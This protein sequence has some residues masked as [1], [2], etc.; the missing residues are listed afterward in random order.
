MSTNPDSAS[1]Y[2]NEGRSRLAI[3]LASQ[4][5]ATT[6]TARPRD[7]LHSPSPSATIIGMQSASEAFGTWA[8]IAAGMVC[9]LA[10]VALVVVLA[11]AAIK[12]K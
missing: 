1:Q 8:G 12:R 10:V 5:A 7:A 3:N 9:L 11:L 4:N 2:H 6:A